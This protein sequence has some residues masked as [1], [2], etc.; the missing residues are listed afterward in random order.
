MNQQNWEIVTTLK[1][2]VSCKCS[3]KPSQGTFEIRAMMKPMPF[4]SGRAML[5]C[6]V[7]R[8]GRLAPMT[9]CPFWPRADTKGSKWKE[10]LFNA[11]LGDTWGQGSDGIFLVL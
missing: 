8:R 11:A 7:H 6:H 2:L 10:I 3:L 5:R 4:T 9:T 1:H